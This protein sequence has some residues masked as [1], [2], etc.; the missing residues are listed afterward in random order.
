M[1]RSDEPSILSRVR[2][3]IRASQRASGSWKSSCGEQLQG[4]SHVVI[5][6]LPM[7]SIETKAGNR[8]R[9]CKADD[10]DSRP[11]CPYS[12]IIQEKKTCWS[13]EIPHGNCTD[14]TQLSVWNLG[15]YTFRGVTSKWTPYVCI[16]R[17]NLNV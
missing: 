7:Q 9:T 10:G 4:N 8:I 5:L 3:L 14:P 15:C 12:P 16:E 1:I 2:H 13:S 6:G 11:T 17:L